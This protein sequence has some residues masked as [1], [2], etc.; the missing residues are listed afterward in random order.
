MKNSLRRSLMM[1]LLAAALPSI[2]RAQIVAPTLEKRAVELGYAYKWF[3]RDAGSGSAESLEWEAASLYARMG[4]WKRVTLVIEGGLWDIEGDDPSQTYERWVVGAGVSARVYTRQ[5]WSLDAQASYNEIYDH[6]ESN[7]SRTNNR[8]YGWN[9][10]LTLNGSFALHGQRADLYAGPMFV[11]DVAESYPLS[12]DDP[13]RVEPDQRLG[14][15]AGAYLVLFDYISAFSYVLYV[16]DPQ[17][18][19]G[20]SLRSRGE[21]P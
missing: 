15:C 21:R 3:E 18:R 6:D 13:I 19:L 10:G 2:A 8:T 11:Y 4:A 14:V 17:L 7:E 12:S 5:R 1:L 20:V 16:D 9:A